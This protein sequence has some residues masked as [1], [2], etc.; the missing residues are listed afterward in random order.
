MIDGITIISS[1]KSPTAWLILWISGVGISVLVGVLTESKIK[2][3]LGIVFAVMCIVCAILPITT[4][5]E[6]RHKVIVSDSVYFNDFIEKYEILDEDG[7]SYEVRER[8]N[9]TDKDI[10]L[11]R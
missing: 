7:I 9:V 11:G 5:R 6:N 4:P 1:W 8:N 10:D 2:S 3:I